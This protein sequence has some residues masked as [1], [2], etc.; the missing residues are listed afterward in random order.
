M[1]AVL[2][3]DQYS[4]IAMSAFTQFGPKLA[5]NK[6]VLSSCGEVHTLPITAVAVWFVN[7][8]QS[9]DINTSSLIGIQIFHQI[10]SIGGNIFRFQ[11]ATGSLPVILFRASYKPG[12]D[13]FH[14]WRRSP[15]RGNNPQ[16][17]VVLTFLDCKR[18]L[19]HWQQIE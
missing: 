8:R 7:R 16:G 11:Y 6:L 14:P 10:V 13:V 5:L 15:G 19:D 12:L 4:G 18:L 17:L 1:I 2:I 9:P 3:V